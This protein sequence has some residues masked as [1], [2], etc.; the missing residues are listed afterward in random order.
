MNETKLLSTLLYKK[1]YT[2]AFF[3]SLGILLQEIRVSCA[4]FFTLR[5]P[6]SSSLRCLK[7]TFYSIE[8]AMMGRSTRITYSFTGEEKIIEGLLKPIITIPGSYVDVGCN[9]PM[10]ISN[11]FY[12][13]RRGWRGLCI[14]ANQSLIDKFAKARP[15]DKAIC[16]LVSNQKHP[17]E[18]IQYSNNVLSSVDKDLVEGYVSEGQEV[19]NRSVRQP[20]TLT[21]ILD[22]QNAS[23]DFD[24]LTVDVE[25][26]DMSVIESLDFDKYR[27]KL[28]VVEVEDMDPSNPGTHKMYQ[29]LITKGYQFKGVVLKNAYFLL[30]ETQMGNKLK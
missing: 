5:Y 24:L 15:R 18:F 23:K 22:S 30:G 1:A 3:T 6:I 17:M 27:P 21:E 9:H 29:Y 12:F 25:E 7:Y 10:F 11:T 13:Y 8:R 2:R 14:D 19:I 26:H 16:A 4:Q 28:I 20:K